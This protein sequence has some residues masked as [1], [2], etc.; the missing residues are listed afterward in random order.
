MNF[1]IKNIS[2]T[3]YSYHLITKKHLYFIRIFIKKFFKYLFHP[4]RKPSIPFLEIW[5]GK[6][7]SLRC[8]YCFHLI[9]YLKDKKIFNMDEVISDL[10]IIAQSA[11]IVHLSVGGGEPLVHPELYKIIDFAQNCDSVKA[12]ELLSNLTLPP[13]EESK[14]FKS[15]KNANKFY[16]R[17]DFYEGNEESA[18]KFID[19]L[20]E[21]NINYILPFNK[22]N[23]DLWCISSDV[24]QKE[25]PLVQTIK[26]YKKCNIKFCTSLADGL[27]SPCCRGIISQE[28]YGL[29]DNFFENIRIRK[30]K[31]KPVLKAFIETCIQTRY[32][33]DC[34]KFCKGLNEDLPHIPAGKD[35]LS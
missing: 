23:N 34:C 26:N 5:V 18:N 2:K 10:N 13:S 14:V 19:L 6:S 12:A 30:F 22:G 21:N 11:N 35:Q 4:E 29:K 25:I 3:L 24:N 32:Y 7:C 1:I 15:L 33:R 20:K 27:L 8:K 9:P 16:V 31:F 17:A 28:I